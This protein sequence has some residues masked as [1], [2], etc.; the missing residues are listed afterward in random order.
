[1]SVQAT[2]TGRGTGRAGSTAALVAVA[3]LGALG[4]LVA[5][6]VGVRTGWGQQLEDFAFEGRKATWYRFRQV[7]TRAFGSVW[8]PAALLAALGALVVGFRRRGPV[9]AVAAAVVVAVPAAVASWAKGVVDRPELV[10][11]MWANARN[12]FPSGHTALVAGVS[13]AWVL[14]VPARSRT[15][16]ALVASGTTAV[17]AAAI[18]G[19]GWHRMSDVVGSLGLVA[20]VAAVVVLVVVRT[21]D[22]VVTGGDS[23]VEGGGDWQRL[24]VSV[25]LAALACLVVLIVRNPRSNPAHPMWAFVGSVFA[26]VLV[27]AAVPLVFAAALDRLP[28]RPSS[29][30]EPQL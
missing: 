18:L 13:L 15:W 28:S 2:V 8:V 27:A 3:A 23:S 17:A 1:V 20:S 4:A 6:W 9:L 11:L 30:H 5:W 10:E 14:V 22:G 7:G 12:S 24:A 21:T 29:Q 16:V 26:T 25:G 19:T